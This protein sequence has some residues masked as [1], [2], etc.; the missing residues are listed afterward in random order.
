MSNSMGAEV[1]LGAAALAYAHSSLGKLMPSLTIPARPLAQSLVKAGTQ[2]LTLEYTGTAEVPWS[3]PLL[4]DSAW[5]EPFVT[6]HLAVDIPL[7]AGAKGE[8]R[9]F[10]PFAYME[11]LLLQLETASLKVPSKQPFD[12]LDMWT[13]LKR[14][15]VHCSLRPGSLSLNCLSF[16]LSTQSNY[17]RLYIY[18]VSHPP[19]AHSIDLN[20]FSGLALSPHQIVLD[21]RFG[22]LF[23]VDSK[24]RITTPR[25]STESGEWTG[26]RPNIMRDSLLVVYSVE[27]RSCSAGS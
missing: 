17:T 27:A 5:V 24:G 11:K 21:S 22:P 18:P 10:R 2:V 9:A 16:V 14:F 7:A 3:C 15:S 6:R 19:I 23:A 8:I 4:R 20:T 26:V 13:L 25:L 1:V 12:L